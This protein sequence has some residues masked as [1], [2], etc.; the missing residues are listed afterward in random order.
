MGKDRGVSGADEFCRD[1]WPRLAA[2][3][4]FYCHDRAVGEELAQEALARAWAKWNHVATMESPEAWL[5]RV[6]LNLARSRFRRSRAE[7]RALQRSTIAREE[8]D[9]DVADAIAV[10]Q[11][12][13]ELPERQRAAVILRYFADLPVATV[14]EILDCAQGTVKSLTSQGIDRLRERFGVEELSGEWR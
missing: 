12:V 4:G 6:A 3:L 9:G 14:A 10:R 8:E 2:S 5:Y 11:A 7:R 13:A 1:Q